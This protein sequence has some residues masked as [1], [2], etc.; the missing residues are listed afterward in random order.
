MGQSQLTN[1]S[2]SPLRL[3][4]LKQDAWVLI[5]SLF[6]TSFLPLRCVHFSVLRA[7]LPLACLYS[8]WV[9]ALSVLWALSRFLMLLQ[10]IPV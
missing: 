4:V 5:K 6:S 8:K 2:S 9:K 10:L 7:S 1:A 3:G